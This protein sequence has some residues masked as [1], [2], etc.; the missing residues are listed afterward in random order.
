MPFRWVKGLDASLFA[1]LFAYIGG[2]IRFGCF[3]VCFYY[4]CLILSVVGGV[5]V[6]CPCLL[7]LLIAF[8][9]LGLLGGG[10]GMTCGGL[11]VIR[12]A[13][14]K[15]LGDLC[16]LSVIWEVSF[17]GVWSSGRNPGWLFR[18]PE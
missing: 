5:F 14:G 16:S 7:D 11:V 8:L 10:Q 1:S 15:I 3:I 9:G 6:V 13:L 12:D 2:Y 4:G 17:V 18:D